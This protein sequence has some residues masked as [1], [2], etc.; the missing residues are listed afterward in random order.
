MHWRAGDRSLDKLT[1]IAL[2]T[3]S[4]VL[5]G[6]FLLGGPKLPGLGGDLLIA[7]RRGDLANYP[8][9]TLEGV[10]SAA[11][12]LAP[13]IEIDIRMSADGTL[14]L[15]HDDTVDRTTSGMGL[16]KEMRD[17]DVLHLRADMGLR[18]PRLEAVL[19]ALSGYRGVF[20]LDAKGDSVEHA[21]LAR[22]IVSRNLV[23][24]VWIAC[25]TA[26]SV[27]AV[28]QVSR[29]LSTYG[30]AHTGADAE[31]LGSPLPAGGEFADI[32]ITA[33]PEN[34]HG[35]ET[36]MMREA[37]IAGVD[38]FITNDLSAAMAIARR[39]ANR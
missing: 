35:D 2:A 37:S 23:D 3:S 7:G 14:F 32:A 10:L 19:D 17:A 12:Q 21:A 22:L 20:L 31:L 33:V 5:L 26:E 30:A 36:A 25:Y 27:R 11:S 29:A 9:N 15:M 6:S 16:I 39:G 1:V 28:R 38:I 34:Y 8:E 18:V 24:Q 13:A 4:V